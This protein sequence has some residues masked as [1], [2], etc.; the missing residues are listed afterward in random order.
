MKKIVECIDTV[1]IL[2][3]LVLLTAAI[4]TA[5]DVFQWAVCFSL[6]S[7]IRG[8]QKNAKSGD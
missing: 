1:L 7:L 4:Y 5:K 6:L 8:G 3:A 2:C